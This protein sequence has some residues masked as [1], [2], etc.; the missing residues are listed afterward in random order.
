MSHNID[1]MMQI[2][3]V[4]DARWRPP[5]V[6]EI[7]MERRDPYKVLI[8]T[9]ISLRTK[10][11]VTEEASERLFKI[12]DTPEK[13]ACLETD[14]IRKAIYPAGFSPSKAT[15]IKNITLFLLEKYTGNVPDTLEEL[16]LLKGVGRKTANLV[17]IE[18]F[19]K[20]G[21]CVD[22]HVHRI[23]NRWGYVSTRTPDET[24]FALREKLPAQYWMEI[25]RHLVS[26]GRNICKPISPLC[27]ECP[28]HNHCNRVGVTIHR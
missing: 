26:F 7:A 27:T 28:L 3:R 22:T 19:Q 11:E 1:E 15:T 21:I 5:I 23:T 6:S 24:E 10:D 18:G 2:L 20:E 16:L 4:T 9:L 14:V 13:M 8:S 12:A 25:N 17:L